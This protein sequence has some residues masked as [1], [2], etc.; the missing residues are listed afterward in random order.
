M[1]VTTMPIRADGADVTPREEL[2]RGRVMVREEVTTVREPAAERIATPIIHGMA[3]EAATVRL[4]ADR[5]EAATAAAPATAA[6]HPITA[7]GVITAIIT[8][9]A[10]V[11]AA[12][13]TVEAAA[14]AAVITAVA[15]AAVAVTAAA[16]AVLVADR[17]AAVIAVEVHAEDRRVAAAVAAVV[18]N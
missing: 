1:R 18:S 4:T 6:I 5:V 13:I 9:P 2:L 15:V 17:R 14:V 8:V 10:A 12:V 3:A 7:I 11:A 16:P